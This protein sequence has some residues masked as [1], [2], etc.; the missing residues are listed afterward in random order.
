[1]LMKIG[2]ITNKYS[3]SHRSLHYWED[4]GLIKSSRAENDYRYY[5]EETQ[6]KIGQILILRK[7]RVPLKQIILILEN[8]N[9]S[10]IIETFRQ[11]LSDID[12][13]ITALS[14]IRSILNI[15]ITKLNENM[16]IDMKVNLLD[17]SSILEIVD[18]LTIIKPILK[19]EKIAADLVKADEQ[20]MKLT[21][22]DIR[23]VYLPPVK[24]AS[25][26]GIGVEAEHD[27]DVVMGK[28]V[29]DINLFELNSGA[30]FYGFNNPEFD[31]NGEFIQHQYE[32]WA[33]IPD[34]LE[35]PAPLTK[36]H[37]SG[38]L[39]AAY[40]SKPVSFDEWKPFGNW[41]LNNEDFGYDNSRSYRDDT[42]KEHKVGCSGWGCLEEHFNSYNLYGLKNKKHIL[43]HIDFLIPI[44]EKEVK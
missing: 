14:T 19:E 9:T 5:D 1:M 18:S 42:K 35:V 30:K 11:N 4:M 21:D 2:D 44:K 41:L 32:V 40:T 10:E 25:A 37:F 3:I 8:E 16:M 12:D 23:I 43:S 24:V 38:G 17:D 15:F 13:E 36:K 22:Q 7:L 39:Y 28:F 34:E 27:S 31:S 29:K 6:R 33:T 26:L 20:L